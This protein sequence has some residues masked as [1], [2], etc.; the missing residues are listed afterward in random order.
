[1]KQYCVLYN[2]LAGNGNGRAAIRRLPEL[3]PDSELRFYDLTEIASL[4]SFL[5]KLDPK[6]VLLLAGGD[7]TLAHF[8]ASVSALPPR[9]AVYYYATG[10]KNDFWRDL[11]RQP[12]DPPVRINRYLDRLPTARVGEA[13]HRFLDGVTLGA[14]TANELRQV[15]PTAVTVT[16]D[17]KTHTYRGARLVAVTYG[18]YCQGLMPSPDQSRLDEERTLS[19]TVLHGVGGFLGAARLLRALRNGRGGRYPAHIAELR[20]K[21][22]RVETDALTVGRCDSEPLGGLSALANGAVLD[23]S[24]PAGG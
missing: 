16:V 20:G 23:F 5:A 14:V 1:M 9:G 2:P 24:I 18:R 3:L 10:T 19:V 11:G 13:E 15:R 8:V 7:G 12:G 21:T 17:G 22:I 4:P 6:A